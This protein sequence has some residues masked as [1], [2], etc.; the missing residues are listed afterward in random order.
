[1][2]ARAE[3]FTAH[4]A[5]TGARLGT[6]ILALLALAG[7]GNDAGF[8]RVNE[9]PMVAITAPAAEEVFRQGGGLLVLTGTVS[10]DFDEPHGLLVRLTVADGEP[11]DV[12][13]EPD[14]TVSVDVSLDLLPLGPV[15]LVL[16]ATDSDDA[17]ASA[18]V[19]VHL[20]GPTGAPTVTITTPEDGAAYPLGEAVAFR[21][22]GT[23][24]TTL[25]DDLVFTWSSSLDG[26]LPGALSSDGDSAVFASALSAGAHTITLTAEDTDG[27]QGSDSITVLIVEEP[28]V[29]EPGDLVFSEMMVNPSATEDEVGEWV[30][31]YNTS[32]SP[33]DLA[34]YTFRDDDEDT[35]DLEGPLEVAPHDYVVLC[36]HL[37]PLVNG[38]VPCDGYF[39]RKIDVGGG[40][41]L[42]NGPDELVLTRPD[43]V[44]IDWLHYDDTWYTVAIALGLDPARLTGGDN[45]DP[46]YWC[47]QVTVLE[48]VAEPG[49]PGVENDPCTADEP[50]EW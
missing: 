22:E 13:P 12:T 20:G 9:G 10:D 32:G 42:A 29:A 38:G 8:K 1:M 40:I 45:D 25:P 49:T 24:L 43:G 33:I 26:E 23:D 34:G 3:F 35:W 15:T 27:E 36:A 19:T 41:A 46:V 7:C 4:L 11:V 39:L 30:E 47:D 48:G 28:V 31:L 5:N 17:S 2:V 21:G 14:G 18:S 50:E 44:E 37:D 16:A 6:G